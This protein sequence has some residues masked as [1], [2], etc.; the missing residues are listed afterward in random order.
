MACACKN[1]QKIS[2]PKQINK[3]ASKGISPRTVQKN[4]TNKRIIRRRPI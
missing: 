1:S 3:S 2:Q 4:T